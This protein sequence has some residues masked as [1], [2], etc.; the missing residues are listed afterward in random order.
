M[1]MPKQVLLVVN[2]S[3]KWHGV[4]MSEKHLLVIR[5]SQ[6]I[7]Q[8]TDLDYHKYFVV[9]PLNIPR[10]ECIPGRHDHCLTNPNIFC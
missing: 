2:G 9:I 6:I 3:E 1:H 10:L 7:E 4:C 8:N 5:I